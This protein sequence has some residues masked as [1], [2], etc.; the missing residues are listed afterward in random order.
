MLSRFDVLRDWHEFMSTCPLTDNVEDWIKDHPLHMPL[1]SKL[2]GVNA[3]CTE[4]ALHQFGNSSN[5][6]KTIIAGDT[7]SRRSRPA[8]ILEP[9]GPVSDELP[10]TQGSK[11]KRRQ[12]VSKPRGTI[13]IEEDQIDRLRRPEPRMQ[14]VRP[15]RIE[16]TKSRS[17]PISSVQDPPQLL[18]HTSIQQRIC[19]RRIRLQSTLQPQTNLADKWV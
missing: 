3:E 15:P 17:V 16:T 4:T 19:L 1:H 2:F 5:V 6:L 13:S 7:M 18:P 8:P 11:R 10:L 14:S 9:L 12:R